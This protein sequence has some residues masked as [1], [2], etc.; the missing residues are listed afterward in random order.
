ML[1]YA[2]IFL[3]LIAILCL[4]ASIVSLMAA[5]GIAQ[6]GTDLSFEEA[7]L[8]QQLTFSAGAGAL[9]AF[10]PLLWILI[11]RNRK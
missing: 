2:R 10:G 7:A 9:I 1:N 4:V 8:T 5:F 3:S 6:L 11:S